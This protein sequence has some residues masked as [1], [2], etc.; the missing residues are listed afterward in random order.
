MEEKKEIHIVSN[1]KATFE[2]QIIATYE[3]GIQLTGTEI[4]SVRLSQVNLSD[5]Y[6][7]FVDDGLFVRGMHI[8]EY[9]Q[10]TYNN[11]ETKRDR[12]LLLN[13]TELRKLHAKV[14]VKGFSIVPTRMY[15][16]TRGFAKL[17]IG[18]AKGKKLFDK[19]KDMKEKDLKREMSRELNT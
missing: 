19:R 8:A 7:L 16:T 1:R 10:G 13:K 14:K 11:H 4:K 18:L 3:A 5:A 2:F 9:K 6:C 15:I 17:E 12:K